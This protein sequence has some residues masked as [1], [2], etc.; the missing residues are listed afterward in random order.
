MNNVCKDVDGGCTVDIDCIDDCTPNEGFCDV[1]TEC[2]ENGQNCSDTDPQ[3]IC[4]TFSDGCSVVVPGPCDP[5]ATTCDT[6]N[7]K[8]G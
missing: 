2:D 8:P 3:C 1:E 4:Y 7:T 6:D 5:T